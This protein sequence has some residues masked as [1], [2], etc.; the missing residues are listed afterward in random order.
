MNDLLE[1]RKGETWKSPELQKDLEKRLGPNCNIYLS[2]VDK[3]NTKIL[4]FCKKLKL[5]DELKA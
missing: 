4:M 2:L 5:N 3:L 1:D